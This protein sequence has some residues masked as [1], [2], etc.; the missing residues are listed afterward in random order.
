MFP[1]IPLLAFAGIV[2][3]VAVLVW[4]NDLSQQEKVAANR[5]AMQMFGKAFH[6]LAEHQQE[7][8]RRQMENRG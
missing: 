8:V 2:G 5:K 4:Y 1:I 6:A 7:Q 3:G